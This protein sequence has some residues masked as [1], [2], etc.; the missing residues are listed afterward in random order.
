MFAGEY[1]WSTEI[2]SP[3]KSPRLGAGAKVKEVRGVF[4]QNI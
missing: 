1:R 2:R 4:P 3:K